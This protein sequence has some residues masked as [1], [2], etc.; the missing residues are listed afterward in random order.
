MFASGR[1]AGDNRASAA[2]LNGKEYMT[3]AA[4]EGALTLVEELIVLI[5]Q[6]L[7]AAKSRGELTAE[8]EASFQERQ[9]AVF[10]QPWAQPQ[11]PKPDGS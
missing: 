9:R 6:W 3:P 2:N 11:S 7:S 8:E 1:R 4:I 5:P 10:A